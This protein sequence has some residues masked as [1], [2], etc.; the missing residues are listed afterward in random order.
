MFGR[1]LSCF[2]SFRRWAWRLLLIL[3]SG[4]GWSQA[5]AGLPPPS[6][7]WAKTFN[8]EGYGD[9]TAHAVVETTD[10]NLVV[11]AQ[12]QTEHLWLIKLDPD[13]NV[14][15]QKGVGTGVTLV[16][17][18]LRP[19][20]MVQA[21]DGGFTILAEG[22]YPRRGVTEP[23]HF[24]QWDLV[25]V[26]TNAQGELL[27][28]RSYGGWGN[29]RAYSMVRGIDGGYVIGAS[30]TSFC[31]EGE[32]FW[33]DCLWVLKINDSGNVAWQ[34]VYGPYES[35]LAGTQTNSG[36]WLAQADGGY[37][38][39]TMVGYHLAVLKIDTAGGLVSQHAYSVLYQ[40]LRD[41][42]ETYAKEYPRAIMPTADGG[43]V[44]AAATPP[45]PDFQFHL[46]LVK[47]NSGGSVVW[48]KL[49][50][51]S[52]WSLAARV[53]KPV[54]DG[55][56]ILGLNATMQADDYS[57]R[58]LLLVEFD[59]QG[60]L[61][62][63]RTY[64]GPNDANY[65]DTVFDLTPLSGG[66][67]ALAGQTAS[68]GELARYGL[69]AWVLKV[70]PAEE[71]PDCEARSWW[72]PYLS[73]EES[74]LVDAD[75]N[76]GEADTEAMIRDI[77]TQAVPLAYTTDTQCRAVNAN[78]PPVIE[79]FSADPQAGTA[80]LTVNFQCSALDPDI[81]DLVT[82][83][84]DFG[85]ETS[86]S[87]ATGEASHQ[88]QTAGDYTA[89]CM[90]C[91]QAGHCS[92]PASLVVSVTAPAWHDLG[93]AVTVTHSPRQLYDRRHRVFYTLITVTNPGPA[94]A[95]PVRMVLTDPTLPVSATSGLGLTPD[96]YTDEGDPWFLLV[97][98]GES[99]AAGATLDRLRVDF[100]LQRKRLR[101]GVRIE[102]WY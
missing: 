16:T 73:H 22:N 17:P 20:A 8:E 60:N 66:G 76:I 63:Q 56:F 89:S 100:E 28:A 77:D 3:A 32:D 74:E 6:S 35:A 36:G 42:S 54:A 2:T 30:T 78:Q 41:Y 62:R 91:D 39:A 86:D 11:A 27:W 101:Y 33:F 1:I 61:L 31:A 102:Q 51:A 69:S 98:E 65:D 25:V 13:G 52:G 38:V 71:I 21:P 7:W 94:L 5:W 37:M 90:A 95:G 46:W 79:D 84:F 59:D 64:S 18:V 80:P 67:Y 99:L 12:S 92:E 82:Y 26:H 4:L 14:I 23:G 85:D 70:D 58:D 19:R 10:G 81:D 34:K 83:L 96:G 57:P 44:I 40:E 9:T 43:F 87:S 88:Y 72:G 45:N 93:D 53:L 49:Y 50:H 55:G 15:W 68:Y 97:P 47:V 24:G 29:E 75:T 48:Q